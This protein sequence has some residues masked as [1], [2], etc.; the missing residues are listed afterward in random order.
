MS[1]CSM[2]GPQTYPNSGRHGKLGNSSRARSRSQH[3]SQTTWLGS[4]GMVWS[5]SCASELRPSSQRH[6]ARRPCSCEFEGTAN[7]FNSF[8]IFLAENSQHDSLK[9]SSRLLLRRHTIY[10]YSFDFFKSNEFLQFSLTRFYLQTIL[11][12]MLLF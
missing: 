3:C 1:A 2:V 4:V 12:L 8:S 7:K 10:P 6:I 5:A 11:F 9:Q